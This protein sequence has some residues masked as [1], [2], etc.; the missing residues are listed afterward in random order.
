[1]TK[2][3]KPASTFW[4]IPWE[5]IHTHPRSAT[6]TPTGYGILARIVA[7]Y[8][9]TRCAPLPLDTDT[10]MAIIAHSHLKTWREWKSPILSIL[11]TAIPPIQAYY[12]KRDGGLL[13][14]SRGAAHGL[15]ARRLSL[16][17]NTPSPT[18]TP[19]TPRIDHSLPRPPVSPTDDPA[20]R[21]WTDKAA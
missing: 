8:C 7:H 9:A 12:A 17:A 13:G 19:S 11:E 16:L 21:L 5:A 20:S 3:R 6:L 4:P 18:V 14:M 15:A 2:I 1:M 10:R